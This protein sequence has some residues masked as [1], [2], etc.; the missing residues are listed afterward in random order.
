MELPSTALWDAFTDGHRF[1]TDDGEFVT[2][3]IADAGALVLP[4]GRIVVSDP[5]LDPFNKP[6]SVSVAPDTYAVLLSLINDEV[7]LIMVNFAEEQPVRWQRTKPESFGVDS[8]TGCLMDHEVCRFLRRKAQVD[9]YERYSRR[10]QDTLDEN[11]GLWGSYCV[12]RSSG[13]NVVLFRTWGGDGAFPS[14]FGYNA[15]GDVVCLV[16]DMFLC[17]DNVVGSAKDAEAANRVLHLTGP[18]SRFRATPRS[19][20]RPGK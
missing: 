14:F 4:T 16:T 1:Q 6:F 2:T 19:S 15:S 10:F 3:R 5:I 8:A 20:T 12:D 17:L 18:P 11:G 9:K 13:A 7:A